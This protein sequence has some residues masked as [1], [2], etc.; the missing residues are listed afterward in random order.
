VIAW[1]LARPLVLALALALD[2]AL[3]DPAHRLHPVRL[4]GGFITLAER[5]LRRTP[6][7]DRA[8]GV[9]LA[10]VTAATSAGAA[11]ALT[12]VAW[13][14]AGPAGGVALDAVLVYF[15]LAG[16]AL[17]LE[18]RGIARTLAAG[19]LAAAREALTLIVGRDTHDLD[20]AEI[21]RAAIE[22]LAENSVD[23]L[24]APA[25]WALVLGPP[26]A[27]LHKAAST[28]DSMVGYRS[29][30]YARFGTASAKLDDAL[31][32]LPARLA[33]PLVAAAA[34]LAGAQS[35]RA[36]SIGLRDR[37]LHASPNSAHG[38]AAFAGALGVQ[39]GGVAHYGGEP[40]ERPLIGAEHEGASAT[41]LRAAVRLLVALEVLLLLLAFVCSTMVLA[42]A[43][44][45]MLRR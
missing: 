20:E 4:L 23:A 17:A 26:G 12:L 35:A 42:S 6:L 30:R 31:A 37:L 2:L 32:W 28:L 1:L 16:R 41:S 9:I 7:P 19:D 43:G 34:P 10:V 38:E 40:R 13:R 36:I 27:W 22:T 25:F 24:V 29:E 3:G 18:G 44:A 11:F 14:Y 5:V 8:A 33:I 39:L 21:A 45:G 15:A